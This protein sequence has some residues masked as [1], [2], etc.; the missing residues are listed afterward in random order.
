MSKASNFLF[1]LL[2]LIL[3]PLAGSADN[4]KNKDAVDPYFAIIGDQEIPLETFQAEFRKGVRQKFYHGKVAKNEVESFR[5]EV[6]N[7]L[8]N[9][10]LL[11]Q[12][13]KRRKIKIDKAPINKKLAELDKRNS[14]QA[15]WA[16][17][18]DKVL[19]ILREQLERE[20]YVNKFE[21][22]VKTIALL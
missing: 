13:A 19:A 1:V 22:V 3:F 10:V 15:Q 2:L 5:K 4:D 8:V 12:E 17:N 11:V 14:K 16:K 20:E 18:R 9:Q 7:R 21:K 6:V